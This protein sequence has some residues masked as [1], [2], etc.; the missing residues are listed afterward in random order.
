MTSFTAVVVI[1]APIERVWRA[2]CDPVEVIQWD[3]TV[4]EALDAPPD[5]P[6]PGQHVRWHIHGSDRVLHDRP[7]HVEAPTRLHSL[8]TVGREHLDETYTLAAVDAKTTMLS[9]YVALSWHFPIVGS[10]IARWRAL[11]RTRRAFETSMHRLKLHC[12]TAD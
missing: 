11:L 4:V 12:E 6:K 8:L 9:C 7:Q 3:A 1:R 5:Y 2:L 10:V